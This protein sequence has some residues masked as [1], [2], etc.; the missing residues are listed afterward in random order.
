MQQRQT[1]FHVYQQSLGSAENSVQDLH[2]VHC[3]ENRLVIDNNFSEKGG[4]SGH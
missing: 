3:K 4:V 2:Q 1:N